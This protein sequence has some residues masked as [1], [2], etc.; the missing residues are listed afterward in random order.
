MSA[1]PRI[2]LSTIAFGVMSTTGMPLPE[3]AESAL[4]DGLALRGTTALTGPMSEFGIE[5]LFGLIAVSRRTGALRIGPPRPSVFFFVDGELCGG[6]AEQ[7][8]TL[9]DAFHDQ[10]SYPDDASVQRLVEDQ[11]VTALATALIPTD[12]EFCFLEGPAQADYRRFRFARDAAMDAARERLAAWR[13][14]ADV[15]PSV[16]V[17]VHLARDLPPDV[18]DVKIERRDWQIV[19]IVDGRRTVAD[20]IAIARR[21]AFDVC[22]TLYRLAIA[23][24]VEL[25]DLR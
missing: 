8:T 23:G 12:S 9:R 4:P 20:V 6:V 17:V 22:S 11:L 13:V 21:S 5:D 15:I 2:P 18:D 16:L 1:R 25:G 24:I 7:D 14:I 10:S 3:A 19:S